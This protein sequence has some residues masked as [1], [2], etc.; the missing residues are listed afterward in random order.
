MKYVIKSFFLIEEIDVSG[1]LTISAKGK[2]R[3]NS[4]FVHDMS[5]RKCSTADNLSD[6]LFMSFHEIHLNSNTAMHRRDKVS[7]I[8]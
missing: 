2:E 5:S 1:Q 6:S 7:S 3:H 8:C 4:T